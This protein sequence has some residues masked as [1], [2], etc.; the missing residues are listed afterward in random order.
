MSWDPTWE[1]VF[2]SQPWGKYP[3][4]ELIRFVARN[5]FHVSDRASVNLLEV[6]CGPGPNL[7][8]L[9]REGFSAYGVDGSQTAIELARSRLDAE[10]PGWKG[11]L[12]RGDMLQLPFPDEFF[13]AVIDNEA[14]YCNDY[15][16]AQ[17]IYGEMSRV[18]KA[19][20]KLFCRTF[21]AGS[22]GD[23]TGERVGHNAWLVGE[24]PMY[25][26]GFS[27]FTEDLE[28]RELIQGFHVVETELLTR[29]MDNGAHAVKEWIIL[30][31]KS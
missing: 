27:R 25:N 15:P 20:G 4:E 28:I 26:K 24:G 21:A 9:A 31:E 12:C 5:F 3:G 29:T 17:R 11:Q 6:G 8:F 22:W 23:G 14:V 13:D 18:T 19:R 2:R 10:C 30:G 16:V 1:G 7:W